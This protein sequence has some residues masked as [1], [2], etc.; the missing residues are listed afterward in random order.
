MILGNPSSL[1]K[2][3]IPSFL[4]TFLVYS[5]FCRTSARIFLKKVHRRYW[6]VAVVCF[7]PLQVRNNFILFI[8]K[9]FGY[10]LWCRNSML[11][12]LLNFS[13]TN[14]LY[15]SYLFVFICLSRSSLAFFSLSLEFR[16]QWY[17][18]VHSHFFEVKYVFSKILQFKCI[19]LHDLATV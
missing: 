13:L 5:F 14:P 6:F 7:Y 17:A 9:S 15:D 2:Y 1:S 4:S 10:K 18:L 16:I 19:I 8:S 12:I 3:L 11:H